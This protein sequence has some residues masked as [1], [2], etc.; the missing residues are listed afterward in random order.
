MSSKRV[1]TTRVFLPRTYEPGAFRGLGEELQLYVPVVHYH[2][3][4]GPSKKLH[5]LEGPSKK[6][7]VLKGSD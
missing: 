4:E 5:V 1:F 7:H 6:P 3:L 2:V